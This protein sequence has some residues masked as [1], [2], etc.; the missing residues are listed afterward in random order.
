MHCL[1]H[2]GNVSGE[3]SNFIADIDQLLSYMFCQ[4]Q[5]IEVLYG[6]LFMHKSSMVQGTICYTCM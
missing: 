4:I 1:L 6:L 2:K 5:N 3:G